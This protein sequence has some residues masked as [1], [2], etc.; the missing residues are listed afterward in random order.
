MVATTKVAQPSEKPQK[1][2]SYACH[3]CGLNGHKL[4]DCP[5]FVEMQR[6]IHGKFMIVVEVKLV[7]ETQIIIVDVNVVDVMLQQRV[8]L[9]GRNKNN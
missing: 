4:I 3:I 8:L 7:A 1:K 9:I 5:K 2:S 6:I